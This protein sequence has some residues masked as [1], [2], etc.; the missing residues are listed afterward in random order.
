MTQYRDSSQIISKLMEYIQR[1]D[2][3]EEVTFDRVNNMVEFL[4]CYPLQ[5]K[6]DKNV[7]LDMRDVLHPKDKTKVQTISEN[8]A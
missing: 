5:V 1:A 6:K 2:Q 4:Q 7:S 8:K 3:N